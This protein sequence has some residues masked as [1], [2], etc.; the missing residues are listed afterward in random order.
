[1]KEKYNGN[2]NTEINLLMPHLI[3]V[4]EDD[5]DLSHLI[6]KNLQRAGF[7][8][9]GVTNGSDA[10]DWIVNK[11]ATLLLLDYR[12]PDMIGKEVIKILIEKKLSIPFIVITG[13]G[14]EKVAVEMMKLG[15][16]DYLIKDVALL[17]LLP[18][19]VKRVLEQLV[20][21]KELADAEQALKESEERNRVLIDIAG[22]TGLGI[23]IVQNT[24]DMEGAIIFA[25]DEIATILGYSPEEICTMSFKDFL[26]P[27]VFP[28][29]KERYEKRQK[30]ENVPSHYELNAIRRDG[31]TIVLEIGAGTMVYRSKLATVAFVREITERK[32]SDNILEV[33][34]E[35]R[36]AELLSVKEELQLEINKR[37]K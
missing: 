19:V 14:D 25:N 8:T 32:R 33:Q 24:E 17:D 20:V 22:K 1:M 30:G 15:A 9:Q 5:E 28:A 3:L 12:L 37:G 13:H 4:A 6:Q 11:H 21:Q 23:V 18:S 16:F 34:I 10:V 35:E 27:D 31:V 29:I 2:N 26:F 7:H 36:T